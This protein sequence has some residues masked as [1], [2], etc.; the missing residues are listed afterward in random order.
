MNNRSVIHLNDLEKLLEVYDVIG[1]CAIANGCFDILHP[2]HLAIFEMLDEVSY[3]RGLKPIVAINS[4][5]SIKRIKGEGRPIVPQFA[6]ATL[7]TNLR[8]DL[9]VVIF[10]E[11]TPQ[12][13]MD[14]LKPRVVV[15][16]SEYDKES[17]IRWKGS[18]VISPSMVPNWSTS[19]II[20][21]RK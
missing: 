14:F 20:G 13:L 7:I 19:A 12:R 2:G 10:D 6:R 4:D 17:V 9:C 18:E 15:K 5:E 3:H 11:D 16:G 1:R 8:W 21:D